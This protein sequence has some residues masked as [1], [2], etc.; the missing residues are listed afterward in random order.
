MGA[1]SGLRELLGDHDPE[2]EAGVDGVGA[3]PLGGLD[4]ALGQ[5]AESCLARERHALLEGVERAP[6]EQVGCVHDVSRVPQLVG[7]RPH[8]L[9]QT[10]DMVVE[11]DLGHGVLLIDP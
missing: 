7:E 11:H 9:R 2:R 8:S 10:L 4:A 5:R 1:G 3:D 6:G